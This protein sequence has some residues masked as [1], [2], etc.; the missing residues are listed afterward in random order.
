MTQ[1]LMP[2]RVDLISDVV[3]PWCI[4]GYLQFQKA[5]QERQHKIELELH[6]LPFELNP[7]MPAQGQ[8][9]REHLAEK[10]GSTREQ[11]QSTRQ[12]LA[13]LGAA[14]GFEFNSADGMRMVNTFRAHQLLHWAGEQGL[15][16]KL[17]LALFRAFFTELLDVNDSE[18]LLEAAESVGL[19]R[20]EAAAVLAENRYA[21]PVRA[22]Q[23]RWM[24]EGIQAVPCFV[25]NQ[26][27]IVQG[28]QD[29]A[30]FGGMLDKMLAKSVA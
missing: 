26:Q 17:Q 16:T 18:V 1:T 14:L 12:R 29:A 15:Q 2:L 20:E 24:E 28:A 7:Q 23:R 27:Y 21:E 9:M 3:C 6:W 8:D 30:A 11:S 25:I 5:L 13:E 10:Y 22:D 19:S 4:I